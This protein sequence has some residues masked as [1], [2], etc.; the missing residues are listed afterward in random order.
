MVTKLSQRNRITAADCSKVQ[1]TIGTNVSRS[2]SYFFD[3]LY[4]KCVVKFDGI[5][6]KT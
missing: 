2:C 4:L 1:P 3:S 5:T 6:S